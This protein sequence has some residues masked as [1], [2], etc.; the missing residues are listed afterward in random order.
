MEE[1]GPVFHLPAVPCLDGKL[2]DGFN[3]LAKL[4]P[5]ADSFVTDIDALAA[6]MIVQDGNDPHFPNHARGLVACLMAHVCSD[7]EQLKAGD[8][9]LPHEALEQSDHAQL[10]RPTFDVAEDEP[11][12]ER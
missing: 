10:Q 2:S 1:I 6:A 8:N 4:D 9:H 3:P 5:K 11:K 7:P 12:P